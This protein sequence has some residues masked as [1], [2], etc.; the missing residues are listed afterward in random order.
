MKE[1]AER[2]SVVEKGIRQYII[3]KAGQ[4]FDVKNYTYIPKKG[5]KLHVYNAAKDPKEM[6]IDENIIAKYDT[7]SSVP[8]SSPKNIQ[9]NTTWNYMT[10]K[11]KIQTIT[12]SNK[13]IPD[14]ELSDKDKEILRKL[15]LEHE[16]NINN[17]IS[18]STST[19]IKAQKK[20]DTNA[21]VAY[22]EKPKLKLTARP[23]QSVSIKI[24]IYV[25]TSYYYYIYLVKYVLIFN[26]YYS[27]RLLQKKKKFLQQDYKE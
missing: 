18:T 10:V 19:C 23:K 12:N 11:E 22:L 9:D 20:D 6:S 15:E 21:Q 17:Q 14:I 8:H 25:S 13:E 5:T 24:K 1:I 7:D 3:I 2:A 26:S 27:C 4:S 16:K